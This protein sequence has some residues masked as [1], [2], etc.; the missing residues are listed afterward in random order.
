MWPIKCGSL[1]LHLTGYWRLEGPGEVGVRQTPPE[2]CRVNR[3][4]EAVFSF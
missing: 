3:G 2:S 4:R 1:F